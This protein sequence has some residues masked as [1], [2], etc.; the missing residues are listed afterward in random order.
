MK[1]LLLHLP[2]QQRFPFPCWLVVTMAQPPPAAPALPQDLAPGGELSG[3][4]T[5]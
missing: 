4:I 2:L 3:E 5:F 1:K